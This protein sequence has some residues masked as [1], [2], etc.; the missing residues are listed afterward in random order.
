MMKSR[1]L[2][3]Y[4]IGDGL[5]LKTYQGGRSVAAHSKRPHFGRRPE[6]RGAG[7]CMLQ[8]Y[9]CDVVHGDAK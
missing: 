7:Y 8:Q 5:C 4:G 2:E 3:K 1:N 9:D 6:G